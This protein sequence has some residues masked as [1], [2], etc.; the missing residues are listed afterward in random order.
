ME[1]HRQY[2]LKMGAFIIIIAAVLSIVGSALPYYTAIRDF[3]CILAFILGLIGFMILLL[4]LSKPRPPPYHYYLPSPYYPPPPP[5]QLYPPPLSTGK[6]NSVLT[7]QHS[8]LTPQRRCLGLSVSATA[9]MALLSAAEGTSN[10]L[11]GFL[12]TTRKATEDTM[13]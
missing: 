12:C 6:K 13:G 1:L 8:I 2:R 3:T 10:D 7:P 11:R 5:P 4:G 9:V